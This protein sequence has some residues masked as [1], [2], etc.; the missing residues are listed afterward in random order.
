[1]SPHAAASAHGFASHA[2]TVP[3]FSVPATASCYSLGLVRVLPALLAVFLHK[4]LD[5]PLMQM[6][7]FSADW[8][9]NALLKDDVLSI[10]G[11]V[12]GQIH[13]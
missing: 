7:H 4:L 3:S 13:H 2:D 11:L 6:Q 10:Q 12:Y 5:G 8:G 1:M 9:F